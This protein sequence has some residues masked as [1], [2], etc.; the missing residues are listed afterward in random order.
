METAEPQ[1]SNQ[2]KVKLGPIKKCVVVILAL[3][4]IAPILFRRSELVDPIPFGITF[5]AALI[6]FTAGIYIFVWLKRRS[7]VSMDFRNYIGMLALPFFCVFAGTYYARL[8][9]ETIAFLDVNA[10]HNQVVAPVVMKSGRRTFWASVV[11]DPTARTL[12]INVTEELYSRLDPYRSP[13]RDCIVIDV[14]TGRRGI[15]RTQLPT[16]F[17]TGFGLDRL[18]SCQTRDGG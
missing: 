9:V 16:A 10:V 18:V 6:S 15:R 14:E 2:R 1:S 4:I 11:P 3:A 7:T 13:G 8:F 5:F 17:D 12:Q